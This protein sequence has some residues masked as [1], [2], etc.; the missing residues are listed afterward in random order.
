MSERHGLSGIDD[1][2]AQD[3]IRPKIVMR[4]L[5][6]ARLAESREVHVPPIDLADLRKAS[7]EW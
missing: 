4:S 3:G 5:G 7:R 2:L 6:V 1:K